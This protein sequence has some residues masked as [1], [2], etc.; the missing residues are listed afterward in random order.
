SCLFLYNKRKQEQEVT[1]WKWN[2]GSSSGH[3][4]R[5]TFSC[6]IIQP[7]T[8]ISEH[9]GMNAA[10]TIPEWKA[11]LFSCSSP[12]SM[13]AQAKRYLKGTLSTINPLLTHMKERWCIISTDTSASEWVRTSLCVAY[14]ALRLSAI[15]SRTPRS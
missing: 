15:Y 3:G 9:G 13:T 8:S 11:R 4:T 5:K 14:A 1:Y 6:C 12:V 7:A 2:G 10:Q